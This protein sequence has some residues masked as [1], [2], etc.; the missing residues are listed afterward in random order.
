MRKPA[1]AA[2]SRTPA[3]RG[4]RSIDPTRRPAKSALGYL[5]DLLFPVIAITGN[6]DV[7]EIKHLAISERICM[8]ETLHLVVWGAENVQLGL[9]RDQAG[10]SGIKSGR[11]G[12]GGW[13]GEIPRF[14][15]HLALAEGANPS[16]S[17]AYVQIAIS[18]VR[19]AIFTESIMLMDSYRSCECL[20]LCWLILILVM[21]VISLVNGGVL[22]ENRPAL[23][24]C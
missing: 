2:G 10:P 21:M 16:F 18:C 13:S 6:S 9:S 15:G 8:R 24:L 7:N 3:C 1:K 14:F 23:T 11:P 17:I 19:V 20:F 4:G 22:S 12:H 5:A